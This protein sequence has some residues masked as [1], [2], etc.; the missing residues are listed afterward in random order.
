LKEKFGVLDEQ[1]IYINK[2]LNEFEF[3]ENYNDLL[4]FIKK[5]NSKKKKY[6][7]IDEIQDIIHFENALRD[8][9]AL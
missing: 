5:D 6:V 3:L 8:L 1:I 4:N 9:Q 7:F 2:E